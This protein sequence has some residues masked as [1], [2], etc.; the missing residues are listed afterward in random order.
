M[1]SINDITQH[2]KHRHRQNLS[3]ESPKEVDLK[4][5][6]AMDLTMALWRTL[7]PTLDIY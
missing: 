2:C 5:S 6:L 1:N 7:G 4:T 3:T